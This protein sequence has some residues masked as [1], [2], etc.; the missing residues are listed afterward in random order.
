LR[1]PEVGRDC[2]KYC[3]HLM[4]GTNIEAIGPSRSA[5]RIKGGRDR[6]RHIRIEIRDGDGIA[7]TVEAFRYRAAETSCSPGY[8]SNGLIGT[9]HGIL[10]L[11]VRQF[12]ASTAASTAGEPS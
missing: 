9:R 5:A 11:T 2:L 4:A 7:V 3:S 10:R 12:P 8:D 6:V 1:P